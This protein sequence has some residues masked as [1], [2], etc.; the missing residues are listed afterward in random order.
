[1]PDAPQ[2][3]ELVAK[4]TQL[5]FGV[6]EY[7]WFILNAQTLWWSINEVSKN[8]GI[9]KPAILQWINEGRFY[10]TRPIP[11]ETGRFAIEIA[12]SSLIVEFGRQREAWL[13]EQSKRQA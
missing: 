3:R 13:I 9:D 10:E 4:Y 5:L 8:S 1:M 2:Y 6:P 7:D 12:R 11:G